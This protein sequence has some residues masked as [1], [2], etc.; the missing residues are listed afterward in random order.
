MRPLDI[1]AD[2]EVIR[3]AVPESFWE[4]FS[5]LRHRT[6]PML[7]RGSSVHG[8]GM[9]RTLTVVAIGQDGR[10]LSVRPLRPGGMV[11]VKGAKWMLEIEPDV[12]APTVGTALHFY[13]PTHDRTTGGVRHSDR[14]SG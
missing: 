14:K 1:V 6:G 4:R 8:F 3:V 11:L 10:V 9:D 13:S 7:F 12:S 5:G 2:D